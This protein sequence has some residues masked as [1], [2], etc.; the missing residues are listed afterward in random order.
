MILQENA[1]L[2]QQTIDK[3]S[4]LVEALPYI[5]RFN[6]QIAVIKYGGSAMTD[7]TLKQSVIQDAVLLKLVGIKPVIVHGGGKEITKWMEKTG[8]EAQFYDGLRVTDRDTLDIAEMVLGKVN[9]ELVSMVENLGVKAIGVSG[10]DGNLLTVEKYMPDGHDIGNVGLIKS[11]DV[12]II[13]DILEDD[14]LPVIYPIGKDENGEGYNI[15][16]DHAACAIAKALK[17][18][19]LVFLTD[20]EGVYQDPHDRNS[21]I[22]ELYVSDAKKLIEDG[23]IQGGM[24]P[25]IRNSID[26]VENGVKRVHILDGRIL[27]C[28]LLEIYTDKGIGTALLSDNDEKYYKEH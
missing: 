27:H 15:N 13:N 25:K 8:V 23:S 24:I 12:S 18:N 9:K 5:Q 7:E 4:V 3:A 16:G 22:S 26:A 1:A 14:Y 21:L 10:K 6:G 11:V 17:A 28:M 19:K 20:T 2:K